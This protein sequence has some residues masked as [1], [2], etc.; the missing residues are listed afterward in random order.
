MMYRVFNIDW[1]VVDECDGMNMPDLPNK[2]EIEIDDELKEDWEIEEELSDK[3]SDV[4]G[5]CHYGFEYEK[6]EK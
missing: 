2:M 4:F 3:I 1:D 5:Y 6:V